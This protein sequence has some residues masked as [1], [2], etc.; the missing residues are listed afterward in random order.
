M[1]KFDLNP[2]MSQFHQ[3]DLSTATLHSNDDYGTLKLLSD[4]AILQG[5]M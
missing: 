2:E 1:K 3:F 5:T 4:K